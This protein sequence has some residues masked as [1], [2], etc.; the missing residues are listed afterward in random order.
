MQEETIPRTT[1]SLEQV[2]LDNGLMS[3]QELEAAGD[4]ARASNRRLE[5]VLLERG[6]I[7]QD[8]LA[9]AMTLLFNVPV[10][11]LALFPLQA[12]AL[13]LLSEEEAKDNHVLPLS[14]RGEVLTVAVDDPDNPYIAVLE[15]V[16]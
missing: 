14:V 2:L 9:S 6:L 12:E 8:T 10:V 3:A 4:M 15:G 11:S 16:T 1:Q 13:G 7:S 5:Q